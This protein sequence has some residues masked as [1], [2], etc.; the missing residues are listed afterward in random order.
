MNLSK[1]KRLMQTEKIQKVLAA[2]GLGSRRQIEGWI[3][4]GR[5]V[6]NGKVATVG[7]RVSAQDSIKLDGRTITRSKKQLFKTRVLL[8]H[9]PI[10]EICTRHDPEG[11]PT[12]FDHLPHLREGRWILV[13]RLDIN[14]VGLVLFTNDG[15]L[16][17]RL[18]H[19]SSKI[20]REYAVRVL[21]EV[22]KA[23]L[24]RLEAGVQLED[25]MAHF[26]SIRAMG[27]EEGAN[28]WYRVVLSEGRKRE[29]R[30]LWESQGM[31]VNRLI[32]VRFGSIELPRDLK[33]GNFLELE[34][35]EVEQISRIG[36]SNKK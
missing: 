21:G 4:D 32:R 14:S 17:N 31:K 11:R 9:K 34:K 22:D 19:P 27:G 29:V 5:V 24:K 3:A 20:E 10:S 23:V 13:G 15:A 28:T 16:A 33:P 18:M 12:V 2:L 26:Q 8:Y 35:R 25:G 36:I 7:D 30:R 6:V 1:E